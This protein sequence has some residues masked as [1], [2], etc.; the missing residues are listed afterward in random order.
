MVL[1]VIIGL[2]APATPAVANSTHIVRT[3]VK[4]ASFAGIGVTSQSGET[5]VANVLAL[6][7]F[8]GSGVFMARICT[9]ALDCV[10]YEDELAPCDS[11]HSYLNPCEYAHYD[12]SIGEVH[13]DIKGLGRVDF[14]VAAIDGLAIEWD[15][16]DADARSFVTM[17]QNFNSGSGSW[18]MNAVMGAGG[19]LGSWQESF[20]YDGIEGLN[21]TVA[22]LKP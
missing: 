19:Q 5:G 15:D 22:W 4:E 21:V 9:S 1:C 2:S 18:T 3:D 6:R 17:I 8:D 14:E 13:A 11:S 10:D 16:N 7:Y 12:A 20:A